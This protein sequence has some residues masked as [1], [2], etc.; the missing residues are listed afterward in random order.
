[1]IQANGFNGGGPAI[2]LTGASGVLGQALLPALGDFPLVCLS[3]RRSLE[4]PGVTELRSDITK[5]GLALGPRRYRRLCDQVGIVIH[6]A[7][8]TNFTAPSEELERT[9]RAGTENVARFAEDAGAALYQ[10]STAF[11]HAPTREAASS[12]APDDG[13]PT[14]P[15]AYLES[16]A[17]AERLVNQASFPSVIFR[18]S[19]LIGDA[20]SGR[21]SSFQGLHVLA[22]RLMKGG[23]P[24]LPVR[25]DAF[26]DF[27][28]RDYV[29]EA[30]A[31]VV[32]AGSADGEGREYWLTSGRSA[33]TV[34][35]VV[36]LCLDLAGPLTGRTPKRPRIVN[37]DIV[38][39][40]I[41]PGIM[42]ELP[43]KVAGQLELLFQLMPLINTGEPFPSSIEEL[44]ES[45]GIAPLP[46]LGSTFRTSMEYWAQEC[47]LI[48]TRQVA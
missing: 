46:D 36:D 15:S 21:I 11:V 19:V 43:D 29:A 25:A 35:Q 42:S 31:A 10:V 47:G 41:R 27:L 3:H 37:P 4:V 5:P 48:R 30:I 1:V 45:H 12:A 13:D 44:R 8:A 2:L 16:K 14:G 18:P 33:L 20:D 23:L 9:N 28:P 17:G 32:R 22:G 39:R 38:D 26:V 34:E 24:L 40:L 7:A 6:S